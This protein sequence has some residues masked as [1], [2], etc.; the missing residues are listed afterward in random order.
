MKNADSARS[1]PDRIVLLLGQWFGSGLSPW[2]PGTVGSLFALPLF[3]WMHSLPPVSYW[4]ATLLVCLLGIFVSQ[5]CATLLGE[6]DPSS[7]VIDEV[8]GVLLALGCVSSG[9]LW[10]LALT[11][12]AFRFFDIK[13]PGLI[14]RAQ[15]WSPK[16]W[17]IMA[18]D[19]LAGLLA[20]A[21]GRAL[22]WASS[23]L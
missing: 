22:L 9:P 11:W 14:D 6:D 5:R 2:G 23:F 7:V 16:G 21:L 17:G 12:I 8:A 3:W 4:S 10:C 19:I 13:K 20:G 15:H 1:L 18:D